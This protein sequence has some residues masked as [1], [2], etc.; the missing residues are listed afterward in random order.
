MLEG[1]KTI[2]MLGADEDRIEKRVKA[3]SEISDM[4]I[5]NVHWGRGIYP[6]A[7]GSSA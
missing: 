2:L 6:H 7:D 5:V 1:S 4:T 3:A